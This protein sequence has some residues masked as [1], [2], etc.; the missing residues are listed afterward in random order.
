MPLFRGDPSFFP[1][2]ALHCVMPS[3]GD[4]VLILLIAL[5]GWPLFRKLDWTDRPGSWGYVLMIGVG[6][7]LSVLVEHSGLAAGRWEYNGQMPLIPIFHV[8][9]VPSL[10][11][12]VLPP[13]IFAVYAMLGTNARSYRS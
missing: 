2:R 8:G 6:F 10:Q 4:G 13:L 11:L 7:A 1:N 3:L 9:V 12:M 5:S